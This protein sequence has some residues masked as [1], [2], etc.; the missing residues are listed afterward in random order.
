[1]IVMFVILLVWLVKEQ[2]LINVQA[3]TLIKDDSSTSFHVNYAQI[4]MLVQNLMLKHSNV[5]KYVVT[6]FFHKSIMSVMMEI[7][8]QVM[9][10]ILRVKSRQIIYALVNL[11]IAHQF[12][13]LNAIYQIL[14]KIFEELWFVIKQLFLVCWLMKTI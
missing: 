10:A 1:M 14:I 13:V 12:L 9:D 8:E 11:Q 7:S 2:A 4:L 3:V 6:E 5:K